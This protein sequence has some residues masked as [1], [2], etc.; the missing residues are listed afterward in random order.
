[1]KITPYLLWLNGFEPYNVGTGCWRQMLSNPI[2]SHTM[3]MI[4]SP[5][6]NGL[7][8]IRYHAYGVD[9]G[10]RVRTYQDLMKFSEVMA[11]NRH[12][13][14]DV[15]P[16]MLTIPSQYTENDW[17][18]GDLDQNLFNEKTYQYEQ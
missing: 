4:I 3:E 16:I 1:M 18:R 17:E 9:C 5:A 8:D 7:W 13:Y 10:F 2:T 6:N 12:G 14:T 15:G 11:N